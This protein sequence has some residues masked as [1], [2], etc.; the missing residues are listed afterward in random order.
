M[1]PR[2]NSLYD[3]WSI[4]HAATGVGLT[5]IFGPWLALLLMVLWEPLEILILSKIIAKRGII[6]GHETLRN[7]LSDLIFDC[8]GIAIGTLLIKL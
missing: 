4:I 5:I 6:F 8:A 7:S 1:P 2:N 3:G